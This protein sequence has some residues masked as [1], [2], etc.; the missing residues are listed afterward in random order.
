[1]VLSAR[2]C[3]IIVAMAEDDGSDLLAAYL[4]SL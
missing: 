4:E 1:M 2:S 3:I